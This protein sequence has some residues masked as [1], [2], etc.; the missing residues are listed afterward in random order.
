VAV[1]RDERD[2]ELAERAAQLLAT[3]L[4]YVD[5]EG[6]AETEP[7]VDRPDPMD[8]E[9]NPL[10]A[11][12][13]LQVVVDRVDRAELVP[14]NETFTPLVTHWLAWELQTSGMNRPA[15]A[16][17]QKFLARF[18]NHR[19]APLVQWEQA[20]T[21]ATM[22]LYFKTGSPDAVEPT[23]L[24]AGARSRLA[25]YVGSTP[26]TDANRNDGEALQRAVDLARA[27]P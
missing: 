2:R 4:T 17:Q 1:V 24:A 5:L 3:S 16:A 11:E 12:K 8:F 9:P 15:L 10:V 20:E 13:K 6:P 23:R 21:Y 27:K 22:S 19:D 25:Q 14:Q 7:M 18:P 26:W